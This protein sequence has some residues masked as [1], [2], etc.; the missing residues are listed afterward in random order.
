[1]SLSSE[2]YRDHLRSTSLRA[3]FSFDDVV[4]PDERGIGVNG[5]R[6]CYLDW[7]TPGKP[8]ILFLHGGA[9]TAHTWDLCC[10]ALR[11]DYHCLAL[12]QRGHGDS[13]WAPDADYSIAVQREDIKGFAAALGLD[14]FI[15]V[16]MS[17]GAINGLAYAIAY[18]ETLSALVLI[19]AGPS[20]RRPGSR[21]IRDFVHGGAE[22]ETLEAIVARALAFNPRRDP[23]I[24]RRSL[25]HNLRRQEDGTWV[26]KY[27]RQRFRAMADDRHGAERHRL[28]DGLA[29]VIC[30]TLVVRGSESDVFH[31]EDA[32]RLAAG[33]PDGRWVKIP[34][35]GHTVQG[36]NPRDLVAALRLFLDRA[37]I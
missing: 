6:L 14:R 37:A 33:L 3:G 36:D 18:P 31:D 27:D 28:A 4:L 2:E 12:D 21:R 26:W 22:P 8:P 32:E 23:I 35:A 9:L 29:E 10:L 25:M 1:M 16:G 17:M 11:A 30:P 15:L 19:D 24:L 34:Q 13:D 5:L 7:G 20:L